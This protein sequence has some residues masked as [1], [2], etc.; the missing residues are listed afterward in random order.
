M[1]SETVRK[2]EQAE[3]VADEKITA[4]QIIANQIVDK[5]KDE[6]NAKRDEIINSAKTQASQI[7]GQSEA[8]YSMKMK[9]ADSKREEI[10]KEM[11]DIASKNE[12]EIFDAVKEI[13]IP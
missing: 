11:Y 5:A 6:A 9:N 10:T 12:S 2:I 13:L 8:D 4:A 1:A 3:T 7:I